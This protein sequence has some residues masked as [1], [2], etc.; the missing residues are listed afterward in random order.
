MSSVTFLGFLGTT[1]YLKF[2]LS[3][4]CVN[5]PAVE[6][7]HHWDNCPHIRTSNPPFTGHV[8]VELVKYVRAHTR[9]GRSCQRHGGGA[10]ELMSQ[11]TQLLVVG[12][13]VV[14]PLTDAV[15]LIY[16]KPMFH[17]LNT[18]NAGREDVAW[19]RLAEERVQQI[20]VPSRVPN[21][22]LTKWLNF[23]YI[24]VHKDKDKYVC[25]PL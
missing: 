23:D 2:T 21:Q 12:P 5:L 24:T 9:S 6:R 16:H 8:H 17:N 13:E 15:S 25:S 1:A 20:V 14:S 22:T 10:G 18:I 11:L 7:D 19:R 4:L 3:K